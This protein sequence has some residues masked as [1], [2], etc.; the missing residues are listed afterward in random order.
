MSVRAAAALLSALFCAGPVLAAEILVD[1]AWLEP[2]LPDQELVV[3]DMT[4]DDLQYTR[5]HIPGA[6]RIAYHELIKP[7]G[8]DKPPARLTDPE[9]FAL[10]GQSGITRDRH[11]VIYD[12]LGGLNAGRLFLELE[13]L[14]HPAVSVLDGGLVKWVLDGRR[15]DNRVATRPPATYT[16]SGGRREN[17][18][19][20][21]E[22]K[23]AKPDAVLL[24]DVRSRDEYQGDPKQPRSGHVPGARLWPWE[25][26][27]R[28]DGGF[29]VR[30]ARELRASLDTVGLGDKRVPVVL[31][32]R[33]GH[34]A[35]QTYLTL[36]HLGYENVRVF[37]GSMLEYLLDAGA[38][39][40]RGLV[41]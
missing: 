32:C 1:G 18:A 5:Y 34:R 4:D 31:Y 20:V 40:K 12:D 36:R 41:P 26:A 16:V 39:V 17:I 30:D 11:V 10:L 2:R 37:A 13:R 8:P 29:V 14:G 27:I 19:T 7:R 24:L 22:V 35:G 33:S 38:P 28:T 15:V 9:L 3:I 21:Q 25:Q 6:V 23:Q